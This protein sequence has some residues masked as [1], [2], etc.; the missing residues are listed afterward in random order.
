[1][2]ISIVFIYLN[3]QAL[4]GGTFFPKLSSSLAHEALYIILACLKLL[5]VEAVS[6]CSSIA[7]GAVQYGKWVSFLQT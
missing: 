4:N 1:M 6:V 7:S 3:L 2:S 5:L